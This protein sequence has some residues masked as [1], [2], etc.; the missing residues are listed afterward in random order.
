MHKTCAYT[1][2]FLGM[3]R[4]ITHPKPSFLARTRTRAR[5][6]H[7]CWKGLDDIEAQESSIGAQYGS[8]TSNWED[9]LFDVSA[10]TSTFYWSDDPKNDLLDY[11]GVLPEIV[12][13]TEEELNEEIMTGNYDK[14]GDSYSRV[15]LW[16]EERSI[17]DI[18]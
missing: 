15:S 13:L 2:T 1:L 10:G 14:S 9:D 7:S 16:G 4:A 8:M 17:Q 5:Q 6:T 12:I 18:A 11:R 3:A